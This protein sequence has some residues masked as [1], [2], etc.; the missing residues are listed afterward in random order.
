MHADRNRR[1]RARTRRV[2]DH[3]PADE[4]EAGLL[5]GLA[6]SNRLKVPWALGRSPGGHMQCQNCGRAASAFLR[7]SALRPR[8]LHTKRRRIRGE[9]AGRPP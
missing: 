1:Y 8:R 4:H 9:S 7:L 5:D 3:S 2:T 6:V